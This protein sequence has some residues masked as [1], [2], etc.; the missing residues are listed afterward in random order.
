MG[1]LEKRLCPLLRVIR[2]SRLITPTARQ[3]LSLLRCRADA[4]TTAAETRPAALGF[5][6][7]V[8]EQEQIVIAGNKFVTE[9]FLIRRRVSPAGDIVPRGKNHAV[10]VSDGLILVLCSA[11]IG[12]KERIESL[13]Q[14]GRIRS[15]HLSHL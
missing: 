5:A 7:V 1:F 10:I 13:L 6:L 15:S 14:S 4:P 2:R 11:R 8:L 9:Q 12:Q 3:I